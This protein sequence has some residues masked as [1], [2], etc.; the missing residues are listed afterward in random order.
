MRP[1]N[2]RHKK[3]K[4]YPS[5][6][7]ILWSAANTVERARGD[8]PV[9][10]WTKR[11]WL[12]FRLKIV[13]AYIFNHRMSK[14]SRTHVYTCTQHTHTLTCECGSGGLLLTAGTHSTV[15]VWLNK[16][17]LQHGKQ[18]VLWVSDLSA[19]LPKCQLAEKE[20]SL[21]L[22]KHAVLACLVR[23]LG[24]KCNR[25]PFICTVPSAL[26]PLLPPP[27]HTLNNGIRCFPS[28]FMYSLIFKCGE[29][30][31]LSYS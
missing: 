9:P 24:S 3:F 26:L 5:F 11:F 29:V 23:A 16:S 6:F 20:I 1:S 19:T 10:T 27:P 2:S 8:F 14:S 28:S 25:T 30:T 31:V 21:F 15:A 13:G 7:A 22:M 17:R 18:I 12:P 4:N